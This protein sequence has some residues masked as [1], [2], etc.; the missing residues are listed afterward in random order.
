MPG[1]PT[2]ST[3]AGEF[4]GAGRSVMRVDKKV[5]VSRRGVRLRGDGSGVLSGTG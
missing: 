1:A 4:Q 3:P 2:G 5:S